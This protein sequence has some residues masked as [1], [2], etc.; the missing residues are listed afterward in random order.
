MSGYLVVRSDD[1]YVFALTS[2]DGA[3]LWVADR[4]VVNND[5]LHGP[6]S[7]RGVAALGAGL[8]PIRIE[9]FNK[10][11]GT[12]LSMEMAPVGSKLAEVP[13]AFFKRLAP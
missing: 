2:D 13:A 12:A 3:K 11:G 1:A 10:T 9:W 8:H 6:V 7:V 4:L 5:G